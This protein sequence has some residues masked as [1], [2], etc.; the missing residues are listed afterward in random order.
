[1]RAVSPQTAKR[2]RAVYVLMAM[3]LVL[4]ALLGFA[5]YKINKLESRNYQG[6]LSGNVVRE[7]ARYAMEELGSPERARLAELQPR[8]CAHIYPGGVR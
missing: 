3:N 5:I 6:C 1:M 2:L 8:D 7:V 4:F